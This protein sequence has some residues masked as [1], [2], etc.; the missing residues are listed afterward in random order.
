VGRA[1][2]DPNELLEQLQADHQV[3]RWGPLPPPE[4]SHH[5]ADTLAPDTSSLDY[6][7]QHWAFADSYQATIP[8]TGLRGKAEALVGRLTYKVLGPYLRQERE[9]LAHA[10]QVIDGLDQRCTQL[11]LRNRELAEAMLDRQ[12]AEAE[13]QA[14]LAVWLHVNPPTG[15]LPV[16]GPAGGDEGDTPSMS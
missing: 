10:V 3:L 9:F 13:N 1:A 5:G 14:K 12:V 16:G 2:R 7:H 4:R 8:S 15:D 11:E 6:L